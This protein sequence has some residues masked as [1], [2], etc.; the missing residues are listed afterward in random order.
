MKVERAGMPGNAMPGTPSIWKGSNSPCQWIE[1]SSS[2]SLTTWR[3]TFWP[4]RR[5]MSGAGT[6]PLMPIAW[7]C[8]PSIIII[9][10][11][12]FS[13]MSSPETVGNGLAMPADTGCAH[14]GI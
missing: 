10:W 11:A 12:T 8:R 9:W 1:V 2:S 5:R 6:V 3:R 14:A 4:S 13:V 7:L